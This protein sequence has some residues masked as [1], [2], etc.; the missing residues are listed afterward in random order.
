MRSCCWLSCR[1]ACGKAAEPTAARACGTP[2]WRWRSSPCRARASVGTVL[3]VRP[4]CRPGRLPA[5]HGLRS[6]LSSQVRRP[7]LAPHGRLSVPRVLGR[8][9][10]TPFVSFIIERRRQMHE[11]ARSRTHERGEAARGGTVATKAR[12]PHSV[13]A[14]SCETIAARACTVGAFPIASTAAVLMD[15]V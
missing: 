5:L 8:P 6:A 11:A 15:L 4:P 3:R 14:A 9:A 10:V 12:P 2:R 1:V 13:S 7:R